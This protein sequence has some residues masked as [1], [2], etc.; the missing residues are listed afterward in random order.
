MA[1]ADAALY[2]AK[3][4]GRNQVQMLSPSRGLSATSGLGAAFEAS[5]LDGLARR[6]LPSQPGSPEVTTRSRLLPAPQ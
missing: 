4:G 5:Q 3:R 6:I 2:R 1:A